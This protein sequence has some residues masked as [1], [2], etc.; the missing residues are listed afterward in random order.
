MS[1]YKIDMLESALKARIAEVEEYEVNV[2]NF[3]MAIKAIESDPSMDKF[4]KQLTGLLESSQY[5]MRKAIVMRDVVKQH[6]E[7]LK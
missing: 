4:L 3:E 1:Q 2:K 6:L 5:E 7:S